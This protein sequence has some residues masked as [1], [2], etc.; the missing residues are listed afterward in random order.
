VIDQITAPVDI[1]GRRQRVS[2]FNRLW[3]GQS[4][5]VFGSQVTSLAL[6]LTAVLYLHATWT[7]VG[8]LATARELVFVGL[9]LFFGVVVDRHRRRPVMIV[10]DLGRAALTFAVP[11]L[12]WDVKSLEDLA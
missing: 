2:D 11:L 7:Q 1:A 5:S 10:S 12:A 3:L 4:I 9:M 6:P 8:T